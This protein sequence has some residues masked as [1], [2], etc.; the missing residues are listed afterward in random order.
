VGKRVTDILQLASLKPLSVKEEDGSYIIEAEGRHAPP[1]CPGCSTGRLY[2]HGTQQQ[3]FRDTPVHGKTVQITVNRRRYRCQGCGKTLFDPIPDLDSKRL[4]TTRLI[5]HIRA[6]CFR[7]TF[8]SLARQVDMDE[9]TI[10]HVFDDYVAELEATIRYETPRILGIDELKIIGAYRAII[11]N[12]ERNTVF[13]MRESRAKADLLPYFKNLRDKEKVEWVAMDMYHVYRQ[14][15]RAALPDARIVVD[16]FHIQ[17]MVNEV[18]ETMRKRFRKTLTERQRLKLKDERFLLLTHQHKLSPEAMQRLLRWFQMF[19]LLGEAHAL[20]EGFYAIWDQK[21][22]PAAEAA[23]QAW[24]GNIPTELRAD[25]K[26]LTRAM[27]N[28]HDEIFAYFEQPITNAYTES[29]NRLAKDMNRMGRGYSFEVIRAR[30]LYDVKARKG[31]TVLVK[32][33]VTDEGEGGA[34]TFARATGRDSP[35]VV[36]RTVTRAIEYG[37]YIPTLCQLLEDGH[38]E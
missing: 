36:Q 17:R 1:A 23:F 27:T 12:V 26:I 6:H 25:F 14:V 32:E 33:P 37:P 20:K 29:T 13:D 10:R 24:L 3:T 38:F 34:T 8:A 16:R 11:T 15:M 30:M 18:L 35:P 2:S 7:E 5:H 4:A 9:K 19:P 31:G 21:N 22:R 28:W